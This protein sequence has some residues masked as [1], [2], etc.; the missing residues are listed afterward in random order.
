MNHPNR[1]PWLQFS[2]RSLLLV[3][4]V[5]ASF[6]AGRMSLRPEVERIRALELEARRAHQAALEAAERA[7]LAE[8]QARY[9][10]EL[11]RA[12]SRLGQESAEPATE[13]PR[14]SEPDQ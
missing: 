6:F 8:M 7:L 2:L 12:A 14:Q 11:A 5:V 4:L 3:M 1:R 9:Q 10:T 13:M